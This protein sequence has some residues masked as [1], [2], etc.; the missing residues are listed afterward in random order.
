MRA[1]E[2]WDGLVAAREA[3]LARWAELAEIDAAAV[4]WFEG[5]TTEHYEE[6][7]P[8]VR[9]AVGESPPPPG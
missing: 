4:E 8:D 1:D 6:H 9:A 7:L 2:V 3:V 5:E